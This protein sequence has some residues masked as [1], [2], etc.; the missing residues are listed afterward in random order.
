MKNQDDSTEPASG[1]GE[2]QRAERC[3]RCRFWDTADV[4]LPRRGHKDD[5]EGKCRRNPPV[6]M[7]SVH[8]LRVL[9]EK[10]SEENADGESLCRE[11]LMELIHHQAAQMGSWKQPT[12]SGADWCGEFRPLSKETDK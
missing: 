1:G 7:A 3:D 10:E 5:Y 2:A 12:S 9:Q 11:D 8:H 4:E 6:F